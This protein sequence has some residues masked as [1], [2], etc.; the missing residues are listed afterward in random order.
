[1]TGF[2]LHMHSTASDGTL[3][4]ATL[5]ELAREQGLLGMALTD[6]DTIDGLPA[7][8]ARAQ[9][10]DFPFIGGIELSTEWQQ[11]DS[12]RDVHILGYWLDPDKMQASGRLQQLRA[13]RRQRA[14]EI[15]RRLD[16]L[17]MPVDL[18]ELL[19]QHDGEQ[20]LGRPHIAQAMVERG[21]VDSVRDAFTKWLGRGQPAYVPRP[22]LEPVEAV[23]LI[24]AAD[25][26]PV[27]AHPGTGVPD[28]LI[29]TLVRAG[30]GGIEVYHPEHNRQAEQK[31]LRIARQFRLAATGGSDFHVHGPR[32]IG[33]RV[34]T[35][36]QLGVLSG[37]KRQE[38]HIIAAEETERKA[39][40]DQGRDERS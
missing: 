33:C 36:A 16:L 12:C 17:G 27:I 5:V 25:G 20:T 1:M 38:P 6:H 2:D 32:E 23:Q 14:V 15:A 8:A 40:Y 24:L 11:R 35:A 26:V 34:T 3:A 4:P 10:L 37:Y 31:Y 9:E 39:A 28:Q 22:K 7:A 30:V 13:A 19:R 18:D 21:Y 29:P